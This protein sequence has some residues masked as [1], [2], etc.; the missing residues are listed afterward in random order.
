MGMWC[1]GNDPKRTAGDFRQALETEFQG[2]FSDIV[3][4]I[5]D[6]SSKRRYLGSFRDIFS[7][8]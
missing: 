1:I 5:T 3:F 2:A 4:A 6:W 8:E 7:S